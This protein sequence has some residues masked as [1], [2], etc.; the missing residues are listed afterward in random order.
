MQKT[1]YLAVFL[2]FGIAFSSCDL[3]TVQEDYGGYPTRISP[4]EKP[5]LEALNE[6][7]HAANNGQLCSTLNE[8]GLT[9]FSEVL[10]EDGENPCEPANREIVRIEVTRTDTLLTAAKEILLKN[11][12]YTGV[13][14]TTELV[15]KE[16]VPLPGCINCGRPDEYSANIEWKLT[17]ENQTIDSVEVLDTEITVFV[18]AEGVNRIWGNW[19]KDV[20]IP[21]FVNYGYLEVQAGL[22]DWQID[23]RRFTG[24]DE[25][26]VVQEDDVTERPQKVILPFKNDEDDIIE[27]RY[28][29]AVPI[30]YSGENFEGWIAFIDIEEGFFVELKSIKMVQEKYQ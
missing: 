11:S 7:Y 1:V 14:D 6:E 29:W 4:L 28:C 10:F 8:Y 15:L 27:I 26:Y 16:M 2:S 23:M 21:Q 19:Y 3:L 25:I 18:D 12:S 20:M 24:E 17:F 13:D 30:N 22:V 5:E 9:G